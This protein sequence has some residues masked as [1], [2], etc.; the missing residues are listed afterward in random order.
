[1][2]DE[3]QSLLERMH[4]W[5]ATIY[6]CNPIK[7]LDYIYSCLVDLDHVIYLFIYIYTHSHTQS[8]SI[9]IYLRV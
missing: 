3:S 8:A 1:M 5:E 4:A 9:Y 6:L 7:A 2:I